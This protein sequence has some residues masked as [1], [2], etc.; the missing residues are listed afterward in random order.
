MTADAKEL[1]RLAREIGDVIK[2]RVP[3]GVGAAVMTFDLGSGGTIAYV[4]NA[5]R[6]DMVRALRDLATNLEAAGAARL[7]NAAQ[8]KVMSVLETAA[9]VRGFASALHSVNMLQRDDQGIE[10]AMRDAGL[11]VDELR[12][13][14]VPDPDVDMIERALRT[15]GD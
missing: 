10:A 9:W 5:A 14:Y 1:E 3:R 12:A 15:R 8:N 7:S 13:A 6:G 4:S 11:T 2:S